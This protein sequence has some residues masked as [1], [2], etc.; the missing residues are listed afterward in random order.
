MNLQR[1]ARP[2]EILAGTR[3]ILDQIRIA[4]AG[5]PVIRKVEH[6]LYL[7]LTEVRSSPATSS[8]EIAEDIRRHLKCCEIP[9]VQAFPMGSAIGKEAFMKGIYSYKNVFSF[10]D[11]KQKVYT[12][13]KPG[14][15]LWLYRGK[16]TEISAELTE[17]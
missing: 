6:S 3:K 10:A 14:E 12:E 5:K 2:P 1:C 11:K 8:G 13:M 15:Y 7:M 16:V 9:D 17:R 4:D